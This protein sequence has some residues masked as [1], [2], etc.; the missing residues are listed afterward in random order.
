M[1]RER[2]RAREYN[3]PQEDEQSEKEATSS[4]LPFITTSDV[5]NQLN[6][7]LK[8]LAM[9]GEESLEPRFELQNVCPMDQPFWRQRLI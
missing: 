6:K 8:E 7:N 5:L 4:P 2:E 1:E 9:P 3:M